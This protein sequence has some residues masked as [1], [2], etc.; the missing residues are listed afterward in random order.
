VTGAAAFPTFG[1]LLA[2]AAGGALGGLMRHALI[3]AFPASPHQFPWVIFAE[4]ISGAFLL[5]LLLTVLQIRWPRRLK[6]RLF[7]ATGILGAFTTFSNYSVDIVLLAHQGSAGLALGYS[8]ASI[9]IGLV[10]CYA[11]VVL[12][13]AVTRIEQ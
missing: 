10:A 7:L 12:G 9:G 6:L 5:G 13:R 11:G 4:N 8:L 1:N 2:V 3:V